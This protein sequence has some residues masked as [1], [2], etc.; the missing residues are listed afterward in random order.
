M[1]YGR[2]S[3]S[4]ALKDRRKGDGVIGPATPGCNPSLPAEPVDSIPLPLST[5]QTWRDP[6]QALPALASK[7]STAAHSLLSGSLLALPLLPS[8][9]GPWRMV[10]LPAKRRPLSA[11]GRGEVRATVF[12]LPCADESSSVDSELSRMAR[13]E[14]FI[15]ALEGHTAEILVLRE[16]A[17]VV[18][19]R[20]CLTACLAPLR[21]AGRLPGVVAGRRNLR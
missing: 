8:T 21:V 19:H 4:G 18:A 17:A 1:D 16:T 12:V 10:P 6:L 13:M 7:P 3:L 20:A 9:R 5:R 14:A 11:L 2:G 15:D